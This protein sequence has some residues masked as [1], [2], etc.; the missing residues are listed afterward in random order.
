MKIRGRC[1]P[2]FVYETKTLEGLTDSQSLVG[3]GVHLRSGRTISAPT[4]LKPAGEFASGNRE[5]QRA[6]VTC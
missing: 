5:P 1:P 4:R 2:S 6:L 3:E